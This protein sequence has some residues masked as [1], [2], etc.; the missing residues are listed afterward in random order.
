MVSEFYQGNLVA[1]F[2]LFTDSASI[3]ANLDECGLEQSVIDV[4]HFCD[5]QGCSGPVI[6][7]NL[8]AHLF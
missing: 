4:E 8:T 7:S 2:Q 6:L 5:T 3:I 1:L